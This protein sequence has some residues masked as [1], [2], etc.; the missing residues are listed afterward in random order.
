MAVQF[1]ESADLPCEFWATAKRILGNRELENL[2]QLKFKMLHSALTL[3]GKQTKLIAG[4]AT[5][6]LPTKRPG[7]RFQI[8]ESLEGV[9]LELSNNQVKLGIRS[10]AATPESMPPMLR[11]RTCGDSGY[12]YSQGGVTMLVVSRA[13]GQHVEIND[14]VD[15]IIDHLNVN[16]VRLST[17]SVA[18]QDV[19]SPVTKRLLPWI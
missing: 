9:V 19:Q 14:S 6:L 4:F 15:L 12:Y 8:D 13:V 2:E 11:S 16:G 10:R 7:E 3:N 18:P 1:L 5:M 17:T